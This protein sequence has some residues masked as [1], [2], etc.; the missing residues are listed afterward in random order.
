MALDHQALSVKYT[1]L[2]EYIA[3]WFK[4]V[5]NKLLFL[6]IWKARVYGM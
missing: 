3:K 1:Q 5:L 2:S 6:Q 4:S